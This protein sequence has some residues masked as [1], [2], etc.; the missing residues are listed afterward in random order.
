MIFKRSLL[1]QTLLWFNDLSENRVLEFSKEILNIPPEVKPY[2]Q[3]CLLSISLYQWVLQGKGFTALLYKPELHWNMMLSTEWE[4]NMKESRIPFV[5]GISL[6]NIN[7]AG[8]SKMGHYMRSN[9]LER[10]HVFWKQCD[11]HILKG[12]CMFRLKKKDYF[13]HSESK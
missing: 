12:S 2:K 1:T 10:K 7:N 5:L 8:F 6:K 3:L 13:M 9:A 4:Y 11:I